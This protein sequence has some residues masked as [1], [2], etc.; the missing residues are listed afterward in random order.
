MKKLLVCSV[1]VMTAATIITGCLKD[2]G[3]DDHDYGINYPD[4]SPAGVGFP[5]AAKGKNG[6]G[7]DVSAN[8]QSFDDI[9]VINLNSASAAPT[10]ITV[11]LAITPS[12]VDDYN[13]ANPTLPPM[14]HLPVNLYSIPSL[15]VVI[16][17]GERLLKIP[18][19]ISNTTTLDAN[20]KYGIAFRITGADNGV[21]VA[22]NQRDILIEFNIKNK[23]D[24][25][26]TLKGKFYHPSYPYYPF[27]T[28]VEMHTSGPNSVKMFWPP[29][30]DYLNPFST[31]PTGASLTGFDLQDP[32]FT[33][34]ETTNGVTVQNVSAGAVTFYGMGAGFDNLGYTS[35]YEPATKT[36]FVCYGYNLGAGG[37]FVAGSTRMWMDT[38]TYTGP[39]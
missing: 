24:G 19:T 12:V 22:Q 13:A 21:I 35:R 18:V 10:D 27:S 33:I 26:Y 32:D 25:K 30:D 28:T 11:T 29:F 4:K 20:K 3:F 36:F 31:S 9:V 6:K 39:R 23:Y 38:I 14:E 17:K 1:L 37:T 7:L 16:P 34:N 5:L 15:N 2:K 8:P